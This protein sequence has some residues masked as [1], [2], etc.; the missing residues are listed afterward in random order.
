MFFDAEVVKDIIK[1]CAFETKK[2][3]DIVIRQ[4]DVGDCFY[5]NL[6]GKVSIYINH[7]KHDENDTIDDVPSSKATADET[8][9]HTDSSKSKKL[10]ERLGNF[11]TS[12]GGSL[13]SGD[14]SLIRVP[15]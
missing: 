8:G 12:L 2:P 11:V 6:R 1:N 7:K 9:D 10:R 3:D 4:G 14:G 13:N 15:G 5:I